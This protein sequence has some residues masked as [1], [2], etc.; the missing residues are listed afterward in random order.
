MFMYK[1]RAVSIVPLAQ[2][3]FEFCMFSSSRHVRT[4]T[5]ARA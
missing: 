2:F 4:K 5:T 3:Q 1:H